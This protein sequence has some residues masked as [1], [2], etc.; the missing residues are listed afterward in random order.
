MRLVSELE[1]VTGRKIQL[2]QEILLQAIKWRVLK[3]GLVSIIQLLIIQLKTI[4][5]LVSEFYMDLQTIVLK[6]ITFKIISR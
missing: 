3:V 1:F 5:Y 4:S 6:E 2:L